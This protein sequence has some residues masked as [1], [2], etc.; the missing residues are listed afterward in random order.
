MSTIVRKAQYT[1]AICALLAAAVAAPAWAAATAEVKAAKG[2]E[3]YE[4]VGEGDSFADKDTV[5]VWSKIKDGDG[6]KVKHVWKK[7]GKEDW[8][9]ELDIKSNLWVT[10]SRRVVSPGAWTVEVQA[11]DGSKIGEVAFTVK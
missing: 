6:T 9:A 1:L 10:N 3:K 8:T 7:D 11:E 4:P 5:W 2:V